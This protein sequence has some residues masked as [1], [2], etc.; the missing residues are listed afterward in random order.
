[1]N[2]LLPAD[3]SRFTLGIG[4]DFLWMDAD[5]LWRWALGSRVQTLLLQPCR[6]VPPHC[7]SY[8]LMCLTAA[9]SPWHESLHLEAED[10]HEVALL[11][12]NAWPD[13]PS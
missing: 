11:L 13:A 3:A 6:K 2:R 8:Q 12:D 1:M 5:F 4:A 7:W 9:H 10:N